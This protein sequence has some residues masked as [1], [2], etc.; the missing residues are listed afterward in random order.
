ML[1]AKE[2]LSPVPSGSTFNSFTSPF[3]TTIEKRFERKPPSG[4]RSIVNSK[5][6]TN[7][8]EGSA[9]MRTLPAVLCSLPQA[10]IT[11]GSF[12]ETQT[13]SFTPCSVFNASAFDTNPGKW[14]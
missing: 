5:D 11:N 12:T 7:K 9:N 4:G 6:L 1:F 2:Q 8:P 3:S 10:D 13:I 14:V